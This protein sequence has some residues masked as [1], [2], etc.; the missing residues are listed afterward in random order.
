MVEVDQQV[1]GRTLFEVG[2]KED[3]VPVDATK[4]HPALRRRYIYQSRLVT[5]LACV[6]SKEENEPYIIV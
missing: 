4:P 3:L 5:L 6:C 1:C 2:L